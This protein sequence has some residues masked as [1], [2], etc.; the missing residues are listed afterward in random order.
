M[1]FRNSVRKTASAL[2]RFC[3]NSRHSTGCVPFSRLRHLHP[4]L[5]FSRRGTALCLLGFLR[6]D[7]YPDQNH[8]T[9]AQHNYEFGAEVA[10]PSAEFKTLVPPRSPLN[11]RDVLPGLVVAGTVT[12]VHGK[13]TR[14]L[15]CRA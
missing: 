14:S 5:L 3:C 1:D 4:L 2:R 11:R 10:A 6:H 13:N 8:A 12:V 15:A 9:T 7:Q